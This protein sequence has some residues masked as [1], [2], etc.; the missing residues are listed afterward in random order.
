VYQHPEIACV[1]SDSQRHFSLD[2]PA[3][4][5][6]AVTLTKAGFA[7][8]V[9]PFITSTENQTASGIGMPTIAA[10]Q[11][12][13][14]GFS[15]ATY[16]DIAKGFVS[17]WLNKGTN[18]QAYLA[19]ETAAITPSSGAGPIYVDATY[20][21]PDTTLQATSSAGNVRFANVTPGIVEVQV[22]PSKPTCLPNFGGWSAPDAS[23]VRAP[24]LAGFEAH[25]GFACL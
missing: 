10:T 7:S 6:L 13:Y 3:N 4:A 20:T 17:I 2:V 21:M 1:L 12:F 5:E 23:A 8:V 24:I 16:A 19:G 25:L 11:A 18:P 15:G 9:V 22:G 14:T